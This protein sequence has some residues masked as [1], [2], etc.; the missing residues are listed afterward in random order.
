MLR[1]LAEVISVW[2][3]YWSFFIC[4][5]TFQVFQANMCYFI[6]HYI[7]KYSEYKTKPNIV[8]V[9]CSP[10]Q[11][12]VLGTK[13]LSEDFQPWQSSFLGEKRSLSIPS[14]NLYCLFLFAVFQPVMFSTKI[15]CKVQQGNWAIVSTLW[16]VVSWILKVAGL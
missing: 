11:A 16:S 10:G 15:Y 9:S 4:L 3:T 6:D 2:Q 7:I 13:D 8:F 1:Y 12:L 14:L 5:F